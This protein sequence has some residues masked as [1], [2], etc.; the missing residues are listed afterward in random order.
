MRVA[1][2]VGNLR[3]EFG[4]ARP[5]GSAV[6]RYVRDGWT[7][8]RTDGQKQTVL[9]PSCERG[10]TTT[11]DKFRHNY[12]ASATAGEAGTVFGR[13]CNDVCLLFAT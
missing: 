13:S 11:P 6:I 9:S 12:Q 7:H 10:I 4:H 3:S 2:N 1:S 5:S 8:G